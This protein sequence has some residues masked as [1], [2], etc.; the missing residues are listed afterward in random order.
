MSE[1]S[2]EIRN[3]GPVPEEEPNA[4]NAVHS[5]LRKTAGIIRE[6]EAG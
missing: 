6:D 5:I 3:I 2:Q 1:F 4:L